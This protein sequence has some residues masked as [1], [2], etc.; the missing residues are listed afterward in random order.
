M[1]VVAL[2]SW[3]KLGEFIYDTNLSPISSAANINITSLMRR[4][5]N[6]ISSWYQIFHGLLS[7]HPQIHPRNSFLFSV[8]SR[9]NHKKIRVHSFAIA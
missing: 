7:E 2:A 6:P 8:L 4:S 9:K 1:R 5:S 3:F